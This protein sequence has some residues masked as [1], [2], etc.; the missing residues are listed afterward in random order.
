MSA[1]PR[2]PNVKFPLSE[3]A[4]LLWTDQ[5]SLAAHLR[6]AGGV[7]VDTDHVMFGL[8]TGQEEEGEEES[9]YAQ[10]FSERLAEQRRAGLDRLILGRSTM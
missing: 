10:Y 6:K 1:P 7:K 2:S 5:V 8:K 3:L 4:R 9:C